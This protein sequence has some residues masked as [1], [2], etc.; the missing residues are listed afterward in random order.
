MLGTNDGYD[1]LGDGL[2]EA[3][4]E[5]GVGGLE[6]GR[7]EVRGDSARALEVGGDGGLGGGHCK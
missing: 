4:G 3:D 6:G 5:A 7:R 1:E 2:G